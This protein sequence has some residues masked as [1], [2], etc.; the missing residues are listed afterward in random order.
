MNYNI[1]TYLIYGCMMTYI[2]YR[3]GLICYRNGNVFV[4][5]LMPNNAQLCLYI[6]NILLTGYYLVNIGY[7]VFIISTWETVH[8]IHSII[9]SIASHSGNI[10]LILAMLHYMNIVALQL[11]F[12]SQKQHL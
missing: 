3:I 6:N 8:N 4:L 9:G 1:I 12:R 5:Y 7:A 10:I 11:L 2:I